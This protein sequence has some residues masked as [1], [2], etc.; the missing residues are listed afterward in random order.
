M[1]ISIPE[2]AEGDPR[3]KAPLFDTLMVAALALISPTKL[4]SL[5]VTVRAL[6]VVD[7]VPDEM[8]KIPTLLL[9]VS[10]LIFTAPLVEKPFRV[11]PELAFRVAVPAGAEVNALLTSMVPFDVSVN[12]PFAVIDPPEA[13]RIMF[14]AEEVMPMPLTSVSP[15]L[16]P[17]R[18]IL[19]AAVNVLLFK[20]RP[21]AVIVT[22]PAEFR[23]LFMLVAPVEV[24]VIAPKEL[25]LPAAR[26]KVLAEFKAAPLA[27]DKVD[28]FALMFKLPPDEVVMSPFK[29]IPLLAV[30]ATSPVAVKLPVSVMLEGAV[31]VKAPT[32]LIPPVVALSEMSPAL[33]K[34]TPLAIVTSSL[35]VACGVFSV[36]L[37]ESPSRAKAP[38]VVVRLASIVMPFTDLA[39]KVENVEAPP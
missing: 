28:E 32:T 8:V 24:R 2:N 33:I 37:L 26:V 17:S 5:A 1:L 9:S 25:M 34:V 14:P 23:E 30:R 13:A 21:F 35:N 7:K 11:I 15:L 39:V 19:P 20:V 38:T 4:K 18:L 29:V 12:A 22:A 27:N 31:R 10:A 3:P 6:L 36:T 16:P